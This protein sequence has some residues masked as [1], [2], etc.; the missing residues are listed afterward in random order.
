MSSG[1]AWLTLCPLHPPVYIVHDMDW[2]L[3]W[4]YCSPRPSTA[5]ESLSHFYAFI[6][7]VWNS[8]RSSYTYRIR[9]RTTSLLRWGQ[10]SVAVFTIESWAGIITAVTARSVAAPQLHPGMCNC[11]RHS[12]RI[13]I[14][15]NFEAENY[16][17]SLFM[18][19]RYK[20]SH[21]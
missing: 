15:I 16:Y 8:W 5:N 4:N 12:R 14:K 18:K 13:T 20:S 10:G 2:R 3:K 11:L 6:Q 21:F 17:A 7:E 9:S 19:T 1:Q